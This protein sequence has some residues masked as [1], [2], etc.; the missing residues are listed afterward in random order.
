MGGFVSR[1]AR[2]SATVIVVD[3]RTSA[4]MGQV[5]QS[6]TS[7]EDAVRRMLHRLGLRFRLGN[8]DLPGSPDIANRSKGWAIFV[9]GFV[10]LS[11]QVAE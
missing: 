5:R 3:A 11:P 8:R 1:R 2:V 9:N 6:D 7:A 10:K 4:R